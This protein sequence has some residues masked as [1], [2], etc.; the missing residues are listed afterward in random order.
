MPA[1]TLFRRLRTAGKGSKWENI[2]YGSYRKATAVRVYQS[3]L[4]ANAFGQLDPT[5]T[6]GIR[7]V[8]TAKP[9]PVRALDY[10]CPACERHT[11]GSC[12]RGHC[13]CGCRMF[14]P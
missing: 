10:L 7:A 6:Y 12:E 2:G 11:H 9:E 1:Y 5:Y 3:Q 14:H 13:A 8:T 4:L